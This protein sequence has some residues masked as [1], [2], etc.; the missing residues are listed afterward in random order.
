[1]PEG[2]CGGQE[3]RRGEGLHGLLRHCCDDHNAVYNDGECEAVFSSSYLIGTLVARAVYSVTCV[4]APPRG[5]TRRSR[6]SPV[7]VCVCRLSQMH[8]GHD[9][10]AKRFAQIQDDLAASESAIEQL[11]GSSNDNAEQYKFLQEMRGYVGD[12]L[13]CFSEKVREKLSAACVLCDL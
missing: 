13:E 11:E 8:A 2:D 6:L 3:A 7:C 1:M 10:D 12:L 9:A 4:A 5:V